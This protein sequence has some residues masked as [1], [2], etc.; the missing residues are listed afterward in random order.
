MSLFSR[1]KVILVDEVDGLSGTKDRGGALAVARIIS[2]SAWPVVAIANDPWHKKLSP[3][4]KAC[5]KIE[6]RTLNYK[7]VLNVLKGYAMQ[8]RSAMT[9]M[10]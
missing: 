8:K 4:R 1:G 3:L 2:D 9:R 7:S 10:C 5:Q 6:F